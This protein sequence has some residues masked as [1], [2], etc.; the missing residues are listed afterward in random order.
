MYKCQIW[1]LVH[2]NNY[3]KDHSKK[4]FLTQIFHFVRL[5]NSAEFFKNVLT[6]KNKRNVLK[7]TNDQFDDFSVLRPWVLGITTRGMRLKGLEE[8]R[9]SGQESNGVEV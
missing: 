7:V 3:G 2:K 5:L 4:R 9:V 8:R 6:T 1:F